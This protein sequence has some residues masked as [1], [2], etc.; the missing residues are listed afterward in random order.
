MN[1]ILLAIPG[2][3]EIALILLVVA[4]PVLLIGIIIWVIIRANKKGK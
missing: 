4:I 2:L 3:M 1:Q